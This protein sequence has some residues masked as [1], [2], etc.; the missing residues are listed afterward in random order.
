M[1]NLNEVFLRLR[2]FNLKINP[3]N[4]SVPEGRRSVFLDTD[5]SGIGIGAV[6]SQKQGDE[7]KVIAYFSQVLSKS[8]RNYCVT[9]RELL[10]IV[11]AVKSFQ[12]DS[13]KFKEGAVSVSGSS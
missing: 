12:M 13:S 9:R 1:E 6:L 8:E 11:D 3:G 10:A 4:V 7:E 2:K 5:A